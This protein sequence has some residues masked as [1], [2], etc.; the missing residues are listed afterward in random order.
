MSYHYNCYLLPRNVVKKVLMMAMTPTQG[1][2]FIDLSK[3]KI[4]KNT[5]DNT[6]RVR[7][8]RI[9]TDN[10][11]NDC[12]FQQLLLFALGNNQDSDMEKCSSTYNRPFSQ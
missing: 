7:S 10:I 6:S 5:Q 12:N 11:S 9:L 2:Y 4:L 1:Q 8:V 3:V